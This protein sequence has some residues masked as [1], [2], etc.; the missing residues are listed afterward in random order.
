MVG[1]ALTILQNRW[2]GCYGTNCLHKHHATR[3]KSETPERLSARAFTYVLSNTGRG[4]SSAAGQHFVDQAILDSLVGGHETVAVGVLGDLF[5]RLARA[6][7]HDAVQAGAQVQDFPGLDFDVR[8]HALRTTGRLV[9]HDARVR[10]RETLALGAS[11]QQESA[12]RSGHARA[13]G[14]DVWLDELH[15]VVDGHAGRNR[16]TW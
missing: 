13:Q 7:G 3:N 12:H 2:P 16:T 9:N 11:G 6:L 1:T 14:R 8:S 5:D 15:R 4:T 10:Q